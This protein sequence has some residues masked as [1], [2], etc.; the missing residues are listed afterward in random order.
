MPDA[1][2]TKT[3]LPVMLE[4]AVTTNH[5]LVV[6]LAGS[7]RSHR[8]PVISFPSIFW[9]LSKKKPP[10]YHCLFKLRAVSD[11]YHITVSCWLNTTMVYPC[12]V[13]PPPTSNI[14]HITTGFCLTHQYSF[15]PLDRPATYHPFDFPPLLQ[16]HRWVPPL[17]LI[18]MQD[19]AHPYAYGRVLSV[20]LRKPLHI[21][22]L[23]CIVNMV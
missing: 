16:G 14:F 4:P 7:D 13:K 12:W 18:H 3:S 6:V 2:T 9:T 21:H 10:P 17:G 19:I 8:C 23:L 1:I 11:N 5:C 20:G 22:I 15:C